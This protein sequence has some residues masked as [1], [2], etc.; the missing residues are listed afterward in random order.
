MMVFSYLMSNR[1]QNRFEVF[2]RRNISFASKLQDDAFAE[3][4]GA[5][6]QKEELAAKVQDRST[7]VR[8][9]LRYVTY[10]YL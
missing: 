1:M 2:S 4:T 6:S 7:A 8:E 3:A 5:V 10:L 9:A